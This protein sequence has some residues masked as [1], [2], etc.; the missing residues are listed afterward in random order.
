MKNLPITVF[1]LL[2][3][4]TLAFSPSIRRRTGRCGAA[5]FHRWRKEG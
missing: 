1:L 4:A 3:A 2:A 5:R